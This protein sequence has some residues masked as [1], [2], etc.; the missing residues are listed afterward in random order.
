[1]LWLV[2]VTNVRLWLLLTNSSLHPAVVGD[3]EVADGVPSLFRDIYIYIHMCIYIY[4]YI[5]TYIHTYMCVC[6]YIYIY[7]YKYIY[8]YIYIYIC[9]EFRERG[10]IA[11]ATVTVLS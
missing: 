1:M 8:V 7:I 2:L 10:V 3:A 6:I 11:Y 9:S 5:Y 4:I